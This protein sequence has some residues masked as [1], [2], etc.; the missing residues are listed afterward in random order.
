MSK[1]NIIFGTDGWRGLLDS[2]L[3]NEN[4]GR[5]AMAFANYLKGNFSNHK[6]AIGYDGRR[7]SKEFAQLFAGVL[8][9]QNIKVF[10]SKE[11]VPTPVVSFQTNHLGCAAGVMITASHNPAT[12][13][14]I[15]FKSAAGGPFSTEETKKIEALIP[16]QFDGKT[17][18][19]AMKIMDFMADYEEQI[20]GLVDFTLIHEAQLVPVIDSMAGAGGK[21]IEH[22]LKKHGI[23]AKTIFGKPEPDF[24]G[25]SAEPIEKNLQPLHQELMIND[26]SVGLA[27]DG[28]ADRLGVMDEAGAWMNIQET[29]LYLSEYLLNR[30][31]KKGDLVKTLSVT[32]KIYSLA[33]R[34]DV[35]VHDVQVGFKY[36]SEA[37]QEHK[38]CFGAEESGGFG[39]MAHVPER[40]GVLSALLFLEMLSAS[41]CKTLSEFINLK[42]EQFGLVH[43]SRIDQPYH[44]NNREQLLTNIYRKGI[45]NINGFKVQKALTHNSSRNIINSLKFYLEGSPRWLLLRSSETEPLVRIYAEGESEQEVKELLEAGTKI[46]NG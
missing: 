41:G 4:V 44:G 2:E 29:I 15:K 38:A 7:Y 42:R 34:F 26:Y 20:L 43:Y 25:R 30:S 18:K 5:V 35:R 36:V 37:M 14:G 13:N 24:Q 32:D 8:A 21:I 6:V 1:N 33:E 45:E 28:D 16:E 10:L 9:Y 3:N 23:K 12:Y 40:D 17:S 19:K 31:F 39:F 22:L 11:V 27:T 46:I